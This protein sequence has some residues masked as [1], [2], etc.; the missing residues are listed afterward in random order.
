M[1]LLS[2]TPNDYVVGNVIYKI[3]TVKQLAYVKLVQLKSCIS[4][5]QQA[6]VPK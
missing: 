3:V 6:F 1:V 4:A 2:D 5:L